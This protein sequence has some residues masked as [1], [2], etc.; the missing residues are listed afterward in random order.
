M[1]PSIQEA[2]RLA[3]NVLPL[4]D[5]EA[6]LFPVTRQTVGNWLKRW[7]KA[8]GIDQGSYCPPHDP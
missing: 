8:V 6:L 5:P 3:G 1:N 2:M 4:H 7:C